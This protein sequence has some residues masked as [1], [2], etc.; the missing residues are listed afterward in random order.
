[1]GLDAVARADAEPV[2][3]SSEPRPGAV[4]QRQTVTA[5][6]ATAALC[7]WVTVLPGLRLFAEGDLGI[8]LLGA[9]AADAGRDVTG[10][11][12]VVFGLAAGVSNSF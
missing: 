6:I 2:T 5:W 8:A 11:S 7:P 3:F 4:G 10:L 1:V 12:G 9:R